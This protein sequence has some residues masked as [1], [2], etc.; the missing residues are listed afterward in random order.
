MQKGIWTDPWGQQNPRRLA[1]FNLRAF[2]RNQKHAVARR[3]GVMSGINPGV[4]RSMMAGDPS[5]L[6]QFVKHNSG[7]AKKIVGGIATIAAPFTGGLSLAAVPLIN[8][9]IGM[10]SGGSTKLATLPSQTPLPNMMF[11][12]T[13]TAGMGKAAGM[14]AGL[15]PLPPNMQYGSSSILD[16]ISGFLDPAGGSDIPPDAQDTPNSPADPGT[17]MTAIPSSG[18][19]SML[20]HHFFGKSNSKAIPVSQTN[21]VR[22]SGYHINKHGFY[23]SSIATWIQPG[24]VWVKSRRRNPLNPRALHR[25]IARLVSARHAV[26]RLGILET[27][28]HKRPRRRIGSGGQ[29]KR[30]KAG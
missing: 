19:G 7:L 1:N 12:P 25:S 16:T 4:R 9:R 6:S 11:R 18:G 2:G 20:Y 29:L 24:T 14:T 8:S 15:A 22:P 21:G 23:L 3:Q 30:L 5:W 27:V 26:K 17:V 28:R 10:S 13:A